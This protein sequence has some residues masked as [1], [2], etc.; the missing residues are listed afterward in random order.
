M[1][2][3][4]SDIFITFIVGFLFGNFFGAIMTPENSAIPST[5]TNVLPTLLYLTSTYPSIHPD[6]LNAVFNSN[7]YSKPPYA[8]S[9]NA[10]EVMYGYD[11][12]NNL[13]KI[14][15]KGRIYVYYSN[16]KDWYTT[17]MNGTLGAGN[18]ILLSDDKRYLD[19]LKVGDI[20]SARKNDIGFGATHRIVNITKDCIITKGDANPTVD[21]VCW[22]K[23]D[24]MYKVLGAIYTY[25]E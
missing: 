12:A 23:E 4:K 20:I 11:K 13:T 10:S 3:N 19:D 18:I 21:G 22:K 16:R 24:V 15:L 2:L 14:Y 5:T 17:S 6:I 7:L 9:L 8:Q 25:E 1:N